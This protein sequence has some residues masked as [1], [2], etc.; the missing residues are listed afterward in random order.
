MLTKLVNPGDAIELTALDRTAKKPVTERKVYASKVYDIISDD[1][2]EILMPMEQS[3]LL[4]L[5]VDGEYMMC[6]CTKN[7]L[8]QCS[9]RVVD[10]YK[11]KGIYS[12]L[13]EITS[14]LQK[15]QRREYYRYACILTMW[16]RELVEEER[17]ALERG[18]DYIEE[19]LPSRKATVVDISGGGLRFVGKNQYEKGSDIYITYELPIQSKVMRID[20]IGRVLMS[21]PIENQPGE[22]EHRI[23]YARISREFRE[24]IIRYIF[25][26]ERKNRRKEIR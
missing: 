17:A 14:E 9:C 18:V 26:E 22:F 1:Q 24:Q 5:P 4:L 15:R 12:L 10:R 16:A 21:K 7:G 2:L 23:Q 19:E 3:K 6:F 8:Y 11:S 13:V 25:E 20:L